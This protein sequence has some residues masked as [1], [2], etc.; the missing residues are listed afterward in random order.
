MVEIAACEIRASCKQQ[1]VLAVAARCSRAEIEGAG[2][3]CRPIDDDEFVVVDRGRD[4]AVGMPAWTST[5]SAARCVCFALSFASARTATSMPRRFAPTSARATAGEVN[6][7]AAS[8][9]DCRARVRS[10]TARAVRQSLQRIADVDSAGGRGTHRLHRC[11]CECNQP[12]DEHAAHFVITTRDF[13][14]AH[15]S[16]L[17]PLLFRVKSI[18][19][20]TGFPAAP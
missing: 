20:E 1:G 19:V 18:G 13:D 16:F 8:R 11:N 9:T 3:D 10:T 6:V 7:Y 12:S 5:L 14:S 17:Y 2:L 4:R 15:V